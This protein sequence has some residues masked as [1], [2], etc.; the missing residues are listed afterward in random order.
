MG[1]EK[2]YPINDTNRA[3][4]Q[5]MDNLLAWES[6]RCNQEAKRMILQKLKEAQFWSLELVTGDD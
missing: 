3:I 4:Q 2:T 5:V 6:P 1:E